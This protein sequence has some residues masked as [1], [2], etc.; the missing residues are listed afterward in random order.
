MENLELDNEL[1]SEVISP[2]G[3]RKLFEV[4]VYGTASPMQCLEKRLLI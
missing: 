2:E 4:E 3:F 1:Q